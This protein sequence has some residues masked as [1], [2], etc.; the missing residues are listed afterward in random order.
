MK[1]PTVVKSD[2]YVRTFDANSVYYED[3][4][5]CLFDDFFVLSIIP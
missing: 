2:S 1:Q 4:G 5:R 3:N